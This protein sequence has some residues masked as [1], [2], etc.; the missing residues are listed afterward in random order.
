MKVVVDHVLG[1][2]G[3]GATMPARWVAVRR[4]P[5]V[6]PRWRGGARGGH[7]GICVAAAARRAQTSVGNCPGAAG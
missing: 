6:G 3:P 4:S 5:A 7:A 2:G 1:G